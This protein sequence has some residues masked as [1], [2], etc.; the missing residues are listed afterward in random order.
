MCVTYTTREDFLRKNIVAV[1]FFQP[2][3]LTESLKRNDIETFY[4]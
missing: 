2:L 4:L 1:S 3:H